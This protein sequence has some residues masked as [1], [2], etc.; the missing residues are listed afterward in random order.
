MVFRIILPLY[1]VLA[2]FGILVNR[3]RVSRKI[4]RDPIVVRP[5]RVADAPHRY[6]E[7]VL[8]VGGAILASDVLLNAIVPDAVAER[9]SV[10]ALRQSMVCRWLGLASMTGGLLLSAAAVTHMGASWRIG[11]DRE[12]PGSLV[13]DGLFERVRHPIY[14]GMLLV[15]S[16]MAGVT[17]DLISIAVAAAAWV[18]IPVQARLEEEFLLSV[19][20]DE[21][22][23]YRGRTGRFF[24]TRRS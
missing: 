20:G 5:L 4:G 8:L 17:G 10:P 9:W 11:I 23:S 12:K 13:V 1:A 6:L 24:P 19:H 18:G 21:Y 22:R 2:V 16:G 7:S 14:A 3:S 15:V